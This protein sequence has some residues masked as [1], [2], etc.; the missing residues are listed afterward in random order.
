MNWIM[1]L[2]YLLLTVAVYLGAM[3]LQKRWNHPLL[4]PV[5]IALLVLVA[6]LLGFDI[7]Y[8]DYQAGGHWL[9]DLLAPSVVA[10]GVPLYKQLKQI[11]RELPGVL[12]VVTLS[13]LFALMS[14]VILALLVGAANEIAVSLAPKSVTTPIAV[15][16]VEQMNGTPSLGAIA[17]IVTGLVGAIAGIPVLNW[18]KIT[19]PKSRGIAMGTACHAL[20]TARIVQ[21]GGEQ[22]AYSALSLVISATISAII[23]PLMVP[24]LLQWFA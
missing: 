7:P 18:M 13:T 14:T 6:I 11:R 5:L 15:M 8:Q 10:L 21:E 20:G 19:E 2:F 3:A 24:V 12:M 4:N 9:S 22:G 16:I 1:P 17:V 23:A